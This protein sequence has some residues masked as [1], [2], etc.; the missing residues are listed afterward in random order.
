MT[1]DS[2]ATL[3]LHLPDFTGCVTSESDIARYT[4]FESD[5]VGKMP[6]VALRSTVEQPGST[7]AITTVAT[8]AALTMIGMSRA[9]SSSQLDFSTILSTTTYITFHQIYDFAECYF[10]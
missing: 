10:F 3:P 8:S 6:T 2:T 1:I 4:N 7:P 5:F 9:V